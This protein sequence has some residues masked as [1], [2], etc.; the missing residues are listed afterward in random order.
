MELNITESWAT[1]PKKIFSEGIGWRSLLSL[2]QLLSVFFHP[3]FILGRGINSNIQTTSTIV[4]NQ[5]KSPMSLKSFLP[6]LSEDDKPNKRWGKSEE[7]S[8]YSQGSSSSF[9]SSQS[10]RIHRERWDVS[11]ATVWHWTPCNVALIMLSFCFL[12]KFLLFV[13][14]P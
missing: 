1:K 7:R 3:L 13:I 2:C 8:I 6:C 4:S 9:C 12:S 14:L 11:H 10:M 5:Q